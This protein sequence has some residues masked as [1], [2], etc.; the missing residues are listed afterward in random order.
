MECS[1]IAYAMARAISRRI[2]MSLYPAVSFSLFTF[3]FLCVL[4]A[5]TLRQLEL[6]DKRRVLAQTFALLSVQLNPHTYLLTTFVF[7]SSL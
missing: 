7:C 2:V 6:P 3:T 4:R 1:G 5:Q